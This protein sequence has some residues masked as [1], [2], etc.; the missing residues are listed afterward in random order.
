MLQLSEGQSGREKGCGK[1]KSK[2]A[3]RELQTAQVSDLCRRRLLSYADSFYE[4]AKSYDKEFV[5]GDMSRQEMLMERRLWENRQMIRGHLK[6]MAKIMTEAACEVLVYH[7]MDRRHKKRLVQHMRDEGILVESPMFLPRAKGR[8]A[9]I[10][11]MRSRKGL[12]ISTEEV[13]DMI[14]VLLDRRL[15]P[16]AT[17]PYMVESTP[18]SYI[19]EEEAGYSV[20]TGFSRAVKE[21]ETVSG[22]NYA[23]VESEKG[24]ITVMLSDGTGSGEIAGRDS[25]RVL[26]LMEKMLE[27]GYETDAAINMVNSALFAL[28]EDK[29]HPTL[30][31]CE[32][33][34][35]QGNCALRKVG[36]AV[37]FLKRGLEVE[38]L[39]MGSLPLGI[40]Q[41]VEVQPIYRQLKDGDYLIMVSDGVVDA[42]GEDNYE[43]SMANA[44]AAIQ[45]RNP[46]EIAERL[47]RIALRTSGGRIRD[48]MTIGVIGIW[49]T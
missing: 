33:D 48:D 16:S 45:D 43:V 34:L 25:G 28:G 27:A 4:L 5:A 44:I 2:V 40:F 3:E 21:E 20:M 29:N 7:P 46:G 19:L 24:T 1:M 26:D 23:V 13:S 6:E 11:T 14:S 47:L 18:Q 8:N 38:Q 32:V 10:M 30:D 35:Y 15:Q 31:I 39:A 49:E 36:G 42:F 41:Q 12:R 17:S 9:V 22:D 37:T